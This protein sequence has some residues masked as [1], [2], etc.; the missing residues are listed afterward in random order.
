[1]RTIIVKHP[2][3]AKPR[4]YSHLDEI[5]RQLQALPRPY[6]DRAMVEFLLGVGRRRAQQILAPSVKDRVG[7]N[8]LADRDELIARLRRLAQGDDGFHELHAAT[9]SSMAGSVDFAP[10]KTR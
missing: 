1:M 4:W 8:G 9:S 3:P 10:G 6:V 7:A 2:L 5:I